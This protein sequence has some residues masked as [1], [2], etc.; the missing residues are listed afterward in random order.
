MASP[1]EEIKIALNITD[2][3]ASAVVKKL[4]S[5]FR[6]LAKSAT[7]LDAQ[8]ISKVRDRIKSFDTVGKRN[9]S[10]IQSQIGA[11]RALRNEAQIG[12]SQ[13]KQLTADIAKYSQELQKL[14]VA[15]ELVAG[16]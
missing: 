12:S 13:F 7:Q 10:T 15:K 1:L 3:N 16:L 14:R 9:I 11:L 8:G 2:A 5:S 6:G 4:E